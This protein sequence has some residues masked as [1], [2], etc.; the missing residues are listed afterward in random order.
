MR[1]MRLPFDLV[2]A[3]LHLSLHDVAARR[4]LERP[5]QLAAKRGR[6]RRHGAGARLDPVEP[7]RPPAAAV[8]CR[9][10]APQLCARC[11]RRA[12]PEA[13]LGIAGRIDEALYVAAAGEH[14]GAA[15]A[16]ELR[17]VVAA[18]PRSD[19]IGEAG[20]DIAVQVE[21]AHVER[22]ASKLE[23]AGMD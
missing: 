23:P 9:L 8:L 17:G 5:V 21:E 4:R 22:R 13:R 19:V 1:S 16:I 6:C 14:E 10:L 2:Q 3:D 7:V 11:A 12:G 20:D 18:L 15:L